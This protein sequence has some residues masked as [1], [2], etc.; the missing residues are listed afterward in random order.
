MTNEKTFDVSNI[1]IVLHK[2]AEI[3]E[4]LF[5]ISP[6]T[7]YNFYCEQLA[8]LIHSHANDPKFSMTVCQIDKL[9]KDIRFHIL[10]AKLCEA[11]LEMDEEDKQNKKW[12]FN[13][14]NKFINKE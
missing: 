3:A 5:R 6:K 14:M 9:I 8:S 1:D 13:F 12:Q 10:Y 7:K 11:K 2:E 4:E